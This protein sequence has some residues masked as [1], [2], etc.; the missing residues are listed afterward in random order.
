M[1][2][3]MDKFEVGALIV[4]TIGVVGGSVA[5]YVL[6]SHAGRSRYDEQSSFDDETDVCS[7]NI[8]DVTG[9]QGSLHTP[10]ECEVEASSREEI[11]EEMDHNKSRSRW[12]GCVQR[13]PDWA[14][15]ERLEG[16]EGVR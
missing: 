9:E 7:N 2:K 11:P 4:A 6:F 14:I 3:G 5:L 10:D 8:E 1:I 12:T 15:Y 16:R 13:P